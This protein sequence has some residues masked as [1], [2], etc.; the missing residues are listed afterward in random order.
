MTSAVQ[1]KGGQLLPL[2]RGETEYTKLQRFLQQQ[3]QPDNFEERL[4]IAN[5]FRDLANEK[6]AKQELSNAT[7][8]V[9]VAL[10]YVDFTAEEYSKQDSEQKRL[11][12]Q[13]VI[14]VLSQLCQTLSKA[15]NPKQA[16]VA[17]SLG[18]DR[19]GALQ[20]R[21]EIDH[22][23][24][25][26]HLNRAVANGSIREFDAARQD[27][28]YVLG[29]FPNHERAIRIAKNCP[30]AIRLERGARDYRW[31]GPLD[32]DFKYDDEGKALKWQAIF[33]VLTVAVLVVAMVI[34]RVFPGS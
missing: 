19:L 1:L 16:V 4:K 32:E 28:E 10:H 33:A 34:A 17:A 25:E 9:S 12:N 26:L 22:L 15:G 29:L 6:L 21:E 11:V 30:I 3:A 2:I 7:F 18:L 24:S 31:M 5:D 13:V 20:N 14:P 23:D 8:F 27:A